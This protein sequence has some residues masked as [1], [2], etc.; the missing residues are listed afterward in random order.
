MR[1]LFVDINASFLN[2]TR[3]LILPALTEVGEVHPFGPGFVSSETLA[4][5]L[6]AYVDQ[7][8][9][10]DVAITNT[11]ILFADAYDAPPSPGQFARFY[12]FAFPSSDV[13]QLPRIASEFERLSIPRIGIFLESDYYNWTAP[14]IDKI[15]SGIDCAIAFGPEFTPEWHCNPELRHEPFAKNVTD[16]WPSYVRRRPDK[17][18]SLFHFVASTE[19]SFDRLEH[20]PHGWSVL[21]ISY[22]A[23]RTARD[24]LK[25]AGIRVQSESPIR[26]GIGL[27][28]KLKLLRSESRRILNFLNFD[29]YTRLASSRYSYTCGSALRMPIR[30]FVEI[31]A[32]GAVLVCQPFE[33]FSAA[34][35][36]DGEN[37]ICCEPADILDAHRS[38][39]VDPERAQT[40]ADA[41]RR[42]ISE[43]HSLFARA[44]QLKE[45]L[46][47]VAAGRFAGAGW[48][49]GE[50]VVRT[51]HE[52][53]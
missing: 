50:F 24:V 36:H 10:F 2:P 38:L 34:G 20:R 35:F 16:A 41:G 14:E 5:G 40:I 6:C 42:L 1:L 37:A 30:K 21:G 3:A 46:A 45:I 48:S 33:G 49:H 39:E 19:F 18:A 25:R 28:K 23:R 12:S 8:G 17:I 4:R 9:P 13:L 53:R 15:E 32:A 51:V 7:A 11:H 27:A 26:H 52:R 29:F 22:S 44:R 43:R 47:A 31:P